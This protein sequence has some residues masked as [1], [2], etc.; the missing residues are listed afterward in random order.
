ML[1][2][3]DTGKVVL[4]AGLFLGRM[5]NNQA[6][7]RGLLAAVDLLDRAGA[8]R[9]NLITD[10][11]LMVRQLQGRYR[12]KAP[13]LKPL[14]N[15]ARERLDAFGDWSIQHVPREQ[16]TK[17][18]RLANQAMDARRDVIVKDILGL[19]QSQNAPTTAPTRTV[20]PAK[21]D[22]IE[23]SVI[24]GPAA[25]TCPA[26]HKKG[27]SFSITELTPAGLCV[28]SA[29]NV[30]E[31]VLALREAARGS[32]GEVD[33]MTVSCPEPGCG[34]VFELRLRRTD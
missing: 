29:A 20:P 32:S 13:L 12:V 3:D 23:V 33:S 1:L 34:A 17:A 19:M 18:D 6:E 25:R 14:F 11:E 24:R 9:I 30:L 4:A 26:R 2:K 7:Y 28:R 8:D 5:T 21:N 15:T 31:A 10:S 27:Q 22:D 16:N